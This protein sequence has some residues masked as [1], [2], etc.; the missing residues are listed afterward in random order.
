MPGKRYSPE[1]TISKLR[2]TATNR[3]A[4]VRHTRTTTP[5]T[6]QRPKSQILLW[7]R[8]PLSPN[9]HFPLQSHV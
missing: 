6:Q 3:D 4:R 9:H 8:K 7:R 2:E 1:E 5:A